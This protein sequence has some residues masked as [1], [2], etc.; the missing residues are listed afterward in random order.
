[1]ALLAHVGDE[2]LHDFFISRADGARVGDDLQVGRFQILE[3][4]IAVEGQ[5][6]RGE[7]VGCYGPDGREVARG[8]VNYSAAEARRIM[9]RPSGEIASILG[10]MDEPELIHRDN[11][12]LL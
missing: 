4:D 1:M 10:A 3:Q 7:V 8:L 9:G 12:V 6:E 2:F 11:L 5:F